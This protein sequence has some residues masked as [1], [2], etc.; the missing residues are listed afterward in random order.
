M[1]EKE[2]MLDKVVKFLHDETEAAGVTVLRGIEGYTRGE[3][4]HAT[5]FVDVSFDLPLII[6]LFDEPERALELMK[7]LSQRFSLPHIVS[8]QAQIFN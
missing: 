3:A 1:R 5:S 4:I 7:T 6:E 8:W 2:H